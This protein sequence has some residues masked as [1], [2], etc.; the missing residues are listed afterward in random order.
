M[1][2]TSTR[3]LTMRAD[4]PTSRAAS[5]S[6]ACEPALT[7]SKWVNE[8][9]P[10]LNDLLSARDVARLTRRPRWMLTGLCLIGRFPKKLT[11]RGRGIG[12]RRS[13]VLEWMSRDLAIARDAE[14]LPRACARKHPRQACLPLEC[15]MS[16]ADDGRCTAKRPNSSCRN[17]NIKASAIKR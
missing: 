7:L 9:Y 3:V 14:T 13:E 17:R 5:P 11:Y 4:P 2:N 6:P 15:A 12:W 8:R 1:Q 10:P 16:C